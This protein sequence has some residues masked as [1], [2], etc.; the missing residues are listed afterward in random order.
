MRAT[1]SDNA[2]IRLQ[3]VSKKYPIYARN[4]DRVIEALHP[5][6]KQYHRDFWALRDV[7]LEVAR[8][9]TLGILGVNGSGKSTLLQVICSILQPSSGVVE[10]SG[11][12]AALIELGAG[13][14][15]ELTGRQNAE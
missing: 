2:A 1:R 10:V 4:F 7:D 13:F 3:G 12:V 6:R 5:R 11:R 8:G 15:P 14:S 9:E